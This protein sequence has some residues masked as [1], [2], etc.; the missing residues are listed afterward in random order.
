MNVCHFI[1]RLTKDPSLEQ[2]EFSKKCTFTLAV[3]RNAEKS[4]FVNCVA[5]NE[6]ANCLSKYAKKGDRIQ[7]TASFH[8]EKI[9]NIYYV[10]FDVTGFNFI[11]NKNRE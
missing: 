6:Q 7:I 9:N 8:Q 4:D 5:W 3:R 10:N 2:L 1:G 11:E